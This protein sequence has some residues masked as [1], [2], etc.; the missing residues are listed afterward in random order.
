MSVKKRFKEEKNVFEHD[1]KKSKA[2]AS[3]LQ[4]KLENAQQAFY[5][6]KQETEHSPLNVLRNELGNRQIQIVE[7]ET[8]LRK[9]NEDCDEY[10]GKYQNLQQQLVGL[11][12]QR[13]HEKEAMLHRQ[14]EELEAIKK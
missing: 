2:Q 11:K 4:S 6:Y 3:D 8:R 7:L 9:A 12:K 10:A 13:D 1:L 14:A 5:D